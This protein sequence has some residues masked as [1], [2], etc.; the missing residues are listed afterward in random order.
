MA[1]EPLLRESDSRLRLK[2]KGM[3]KEMNSMKNFE[4]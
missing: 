4:V 1:A 2:G 3:M